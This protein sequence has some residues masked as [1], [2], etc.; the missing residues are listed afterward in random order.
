[1]DI[2]PVLRVA[3]RCILCE[4]EI[5]RHATFAVDGGELLDT[6]THVEPCPLAFLAV[7]CGAPIVYN[8]VSL[9]SAE[10]ESMK[11]AR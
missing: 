8:V 7:D 9:T 6:W 5:V 11:G 3:A 1:M 2:V 4:G 10:V